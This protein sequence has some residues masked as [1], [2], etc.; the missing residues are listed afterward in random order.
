MITAA[1]LTMDAADV[2]TTFAA[3]RQLRNDEGQL[4]SREE[5]LQSTSCAPL[6]SNSSLEMSRLQL[7]M[8]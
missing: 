7:L 5:Q 6:N 8:C 4:F 1:G 2:Q 3:L